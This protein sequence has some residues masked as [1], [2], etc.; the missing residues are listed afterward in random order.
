M[1][2]TAELSL[3]PFNE[4][5][6]PVIAAFIERLR[7]YDDL[8]VVTNAMSTQVRGDYDRVFAVIASEL[9]A[10]RE[11][12]GR[13]VLVCKFIVDGLEIAAEPDIG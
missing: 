8:T 2:L 12:N 13:Q 1:Q 7:K 3:Y 6:V 11:R 4:H 9:R 10:S 5:Y